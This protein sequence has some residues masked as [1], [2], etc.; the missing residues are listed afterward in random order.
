MRERGIVGV[1]SRV[2]EY[3]CMRMSVGSGSGMNGSH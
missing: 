2:Y 3:E 1:M